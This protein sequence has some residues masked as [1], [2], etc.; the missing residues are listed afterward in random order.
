MRPVI[1]MT[2]EYDNHCTYFSK[3]PWY[4]IREN[5]CEA[6]SKAGGVPILLPY[7][8]DAIDAYLDLVSGILI[9]GGD[10]DVDPV[11]YGVDTR[12]PT[13]KLIPQRTNF[14]YELVKRALARNKPILGICGGHQLLNVVFGGTLIQHIPE[15][16][17]TD[18]GH[19]QPTPR[20]EPCHEVKITQNTL[21]SKITGKE[22]FMVNS[23]HHQAIKTVGPDV[24]INAVATDGMV[25][26][27][28]NPKYKFCLG[29]QW[30]PEFHITGAD[31]AI[32]EALVQASQSS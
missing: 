4:A 12:H 24:V 2:L 11:L 14:E 17:L 3:Y 20:H 18:I 8:W 15:E 1:G 26:G 23:I 5:Y 29:V 31:I 10:F 22:K 7:D 19:S 28:E 13:V 32:L 16:Y 25:E 27:I 9:P 21:L 30:H 6:V